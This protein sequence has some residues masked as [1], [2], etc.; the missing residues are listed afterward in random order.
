MKPLR[1]LLDKAEPLFVKGGRF[2]NLHAVYE[3]V[4]KM[5]YSSPDVTRGSPHV[6]DALDLQRLMTVVVVALLPAALIGMWNTGYQANTAIAALGLDAP[7]G[8]RGATL[9][10]LGAAT[11]PA[12]AWDN[13]LHGF[14]HF[15]PVY[16]VTVIAAAFWETLFAG[17]RNSEVN[18]GFI[19]TAMIYT[20]IL[21]AGLPLWQVALGISFGVVIGK[22]IFG[23]TGKN[24]L[25]P[26]LLGWSFLYFAYPEQAAGPSVWVPV[27]GYSGATAL[28]T[29]ASSGVA[30]IVDSGITWQQAFIGQVPGTLGATS[31]AACLAGALFLIFARIASWRIMVACC[32]GLLVPTLLLSG[33]DGASPMYEL[34]WQWHLV[35]GGFAFGA[36]FMATDPVS[37]PDTLAGHWIYG[38]LIG[39]LT[40]IIRVVNPGFPEGIGLAILFGNLSAPIIDYAVVRANVRR[41]R[42][43][44]D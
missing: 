14:L 17:F 38:I 7:D 13:W 20:L 9:A 19:V 42:K 6:R 18:E 30:G 40:W 28:A 31:A 11:D 34:P 39:V 27:D 32:I 23:G 44:H 24:F 3:M 36:V 1:R 26:A 5:F 25:N 2:E 16:L 37:S 29:A 8:W 43:R 33:G 22:E 15:L 12:S 35:L 10:A 21:P 41:R 4:D